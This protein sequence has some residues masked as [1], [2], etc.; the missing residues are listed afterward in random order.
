MDGVK[1]GHEERVRGLQRELKGD[2]YRDAECKHR[3]M[4]I[5]LRVSYLVGVWG[6]ELCGL[7]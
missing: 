1:Q 4:L 2:M 5:T 3:E 6:E 7:L